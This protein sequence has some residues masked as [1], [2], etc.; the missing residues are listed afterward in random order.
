MCACTETDVRELA[1]ECT[2]ASRKGNGSCG[3]T[4]HLIYAASPISSAAER[5]VDEL[6]ARIIN[7]AA[8]RDRRFWKTWVKLG[9]I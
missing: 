8:S 4:F 6:H 3:Q 7:A 5:S 9:N 2:L 1:N